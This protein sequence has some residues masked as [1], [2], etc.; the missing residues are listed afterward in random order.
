M[1]GKHR[2]SQATGTRPHTTG[3]AGQRGTVGRARAGNAGATSKSA[4]DAVLT[5]M[6]GSPF[7]RA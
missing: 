3:S 6:D 7:E 5:A 4:T 2:Q 1:S